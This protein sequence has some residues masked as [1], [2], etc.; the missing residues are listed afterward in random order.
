MTKF[1]GL[2][3]FLCIAEV[4]VILPFVASHLGPAGMGIM[5][6]YMS[7]SCSQCGQLFPHDCCTD[8]CL[9]LWV[10]LCMLLLNH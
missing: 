1:A 2:G 10:P 3:E 7:S 4:L 5:C 9:L 8:R 6:M